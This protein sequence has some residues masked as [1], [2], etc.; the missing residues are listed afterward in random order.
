MALGVAVLPSVCH[1]RV[2][3]WSQPVSGSLQQHLVM[4]ALDVFVA[5]Q[6]KNRQG[7]TLDIQWAFGGANFEGSQLEMECTSHSNKCGVCERE[8]LHI[9]K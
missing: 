1:Y 4:A 7:L 8:K 9:H 2:A 6:R 5:V 3:A